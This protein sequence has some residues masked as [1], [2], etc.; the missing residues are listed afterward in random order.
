MKK[1]VFVLTM[2]VSLFSISCRQDD[3]VMS[4]QDLTNL[5]IIKGRSNLNE[6][7]TNVTISNR[8]DNIVK[9]PK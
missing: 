6:N 3:E 7:N 2:F 1:F 4:N 9:P 8:E 5:K